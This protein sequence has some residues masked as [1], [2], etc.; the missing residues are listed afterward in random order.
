M[1]TSQ[2]IL[3]GFNDNR[4]LVEG[5]YGLEKS[6]KGLLYRATSRNAEIKTRL[7][8][9]PVQCTL[10]VSA[11]PEH[12]GENLIVTVSSDDKKRFQFNL[13]TNQWTTRTGKL[14]LDESRTIT[15]ETDNPWSPDRIYNNGD[16]RAL[17]IMLNAIRLD[18]IP[19]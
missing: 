6:P 13:H 4:A 5:W 12:T 8:H 16:A 17:G 9:G 2:I 14:I 1:S 19:Q 15:I 18:P 10:F 7:P 3:A 11:R